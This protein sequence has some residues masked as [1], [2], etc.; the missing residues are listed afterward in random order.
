MQLGLT[1]L[2]CFLNNVQSVLS[3]P[4]A[5]QLFVHHQ[6]HCRFLHQW[7]CRILH[8]FRLTVS[9]GDAEYLDRTDEEPYPVLAICVFSH[10]HFLTVHFL[11]C[12]E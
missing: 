3:L 8:C 12:H 6:L 10:D 11:C 1:T 4:V 7:D 5:D 9:F 2:P